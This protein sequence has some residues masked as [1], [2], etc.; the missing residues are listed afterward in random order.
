MFLPSMTVPAAVTVIAPEFVSVTPSG[1]PV[2]DALGNPDAGEVVVVVTGGA[3]VVP[4]VS[5]VSVGIVLGDATVCVVLTVVVAA[6]VV[7]AVVVGRAVV[8]G[9]TT[10]VASNNT[11]T[12]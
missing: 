3:T 9:E 8:V 10:V 2:F 4:V 12:Q 7:A 6:V 1:T 5:V 11:S